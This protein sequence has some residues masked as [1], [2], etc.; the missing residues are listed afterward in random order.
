M[1]TDPSFYIRHRQG[2]SRTYQWMVARL[3]VVEDVDSAGHGS[4]A[5]ANI[6]H[7]LN[8]PCRCRQ[9]EERMSGG[10]WEGGE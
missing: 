1:L 9:P 7:L 8:Q 2:R 3:V 4:E 5:P 6:F 10:L